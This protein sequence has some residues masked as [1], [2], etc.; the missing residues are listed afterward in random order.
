MPPDI[1]I[2]KPILKYEHNILNY[3]CFDFQKG[4]AVAIVENYVDL[5]P[6]RLQNWYK[7][8]QELPYTKSLI[9]TVMSIKDD[10]IYVSCNYTTERYP[11]LITEEAFFCAPKEAFIII[12]KLMK[13]IDVPE[14]N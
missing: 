14:V 6:E 4:D 7:E 1:F 12:H 11:S 9:I 5:L 8:C 10:A 13:N 3:D 2:R